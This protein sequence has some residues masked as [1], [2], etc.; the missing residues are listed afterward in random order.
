M[1]KEGNDKFTISISSKVKNDF[2]RYCE[3]EGLLPGKQIEKLI[4]EL[5]KKRR[6]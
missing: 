5:L 4:S 3:E 1:V 6:S 2:K